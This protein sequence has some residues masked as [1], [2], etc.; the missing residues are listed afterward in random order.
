MMGPGGP[1]VVGPALVPG[2]QMQPQMAVARNAPMPQMVSDS[3]CAFK[4]R[5]RN[6]LPNLCGISLAPLAPMQPQMGQMVG[7]PNRMTAPN[8]R[9]K[10][11]KQLRSFG[12]APFAT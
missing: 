1:M 11:T 8:Q 9:S 7:Q 2:Q 12:H 10:R 5:R 6:N 3:L 4:T